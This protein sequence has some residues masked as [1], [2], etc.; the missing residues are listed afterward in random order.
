MSP[1]DREKVEIGMAMGESLLATFGGILTVVLADDVP[2]TDGST[3]LFVRQLGEEGALLAVRI[4][5]IAVAVLGGIWFVRSF[6]R[7]LAL[8]PRKPR[9][10]GRDPFD[11]S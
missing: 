7:L 6:R 10:S 8:R 1:E 4:F 11:P 3:G 9:L 5:G 2:R